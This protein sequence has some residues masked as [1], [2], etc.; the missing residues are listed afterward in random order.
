VSFEID[1]TGHRA[2]VTGAGQN[3][4]RALVLALARAGAEVAVN[5]VVAERA[6]AVVGEVAE[7]GGR[8]VAA[9]FDVTDW[10][11]VEAAVPALGVDILVNNAG[12]VGTQSPATMLGNFVE[13]SPAQWDATLS[14]NLYGVLHCT[15]AALP[16]MV[17]GGY[18]RV[19]TVIS[20]AART[21]DA[22]LAAYSAAKAGAAAL[23]R[24]VAKA[25]GRHGVTCNCVALGTIDV[26]GLMD[27]AE[28]EAQRR[29]LQPYA[30][31]RLGRPDDPAAMVVL[32]ASD[33]ASWVTGQTIGVS[34]GYH[35][36]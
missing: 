1:L 32:L 10:T 17:A 23:M 11:A 27:Q 29:R 5:D 22:G 33:A 7:A 12:N 15:R 35:M 21:G 4:G 24:S 19:I 3:V 36:G 34:G 30:V 16:A 18:G 28:P 31:K 8:A 14:V 26:F 6:D 9:P 13:T 25:V 20:E 2:L